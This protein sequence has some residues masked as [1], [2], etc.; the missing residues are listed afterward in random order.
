MSRPLIIAVGLVYVYIAAESA[1]M[2]RGGLAAMY[3]GY[4][5][6]NI[7]AWILAA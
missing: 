1:W 6:A 2:G 5:I 4:A 3:A 7:G